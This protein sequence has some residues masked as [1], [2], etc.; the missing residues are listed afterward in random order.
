MVIVDICK[1]GTLVAWHSGHW[2]PTCPGQQLDQLLIG[3]HVL[4]SV[5]NLPVDLPKLLLHILGHDPAADQP[6][7]QLQRV[8]VDGDLGLLLK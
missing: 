7:L 4:Q 6:V 8:Y 1:W 2:A 5:T 3:G